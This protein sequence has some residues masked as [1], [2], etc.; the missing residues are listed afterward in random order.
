[1]TD[2]ITFEVCRFGWKWTR[3]CWQKRNPKANHLEWF[4]NPVNNRRII[5]LGGAVPTK[6]CTLSFSQE[7]IRY[8]GTLLAMLNFGQVQRLGRFGQVTCQVENDFQ[9]MCGHGILG[10]SQGSKNTEKFYSIDVFLLQFSM[11]PR[12]KYASH[13]TFDHICMNLRIHLYI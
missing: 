5:I 7:K 8:S 4:F 6:T 2:I 13:Y 11:V 1:M 9:E 3:Y 10:F 12:N